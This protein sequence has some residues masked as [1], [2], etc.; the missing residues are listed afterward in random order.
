MLSPFTL[1]QMLCS[2]YNL[3]NQTQHPWKSGDG[4]WLAGSCYLTVNPTPPIPVGIL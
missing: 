3:T 2:V 4:G 1:G